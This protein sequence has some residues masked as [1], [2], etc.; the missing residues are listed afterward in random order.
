LFPRAAVSYLLYVGFQ[1][2]NGHE[3]DDIQLGHDQLMRQEGS[4]S[5]A[6]V[7]TEISRFF[8]CPF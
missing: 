6:F 3:V 5:C 2:Q 7:V 8:V 1:S 4:C